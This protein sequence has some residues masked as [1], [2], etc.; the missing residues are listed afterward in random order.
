MFKTFVSLLYGHASYVAR[1]LGLDRSFGTTQAMENVCG[2]WN[3]GSVRSLCR[4]GSLQ[5][6]AKE[7]M[8]GCG[9]DFIGF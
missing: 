5:T 4:S 8:N 2:V 3:F 1:G 9:V 7:L 6:V